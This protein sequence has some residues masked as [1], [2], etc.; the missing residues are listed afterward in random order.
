MGS[1]E[2]EEESAETALPCKAPARTY[3]SW[4]NKPELLRT[5][6]WLPALGPEQFPARKHRAGVR[7]CC[8][9]Q[10]WQR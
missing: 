4:E 7:R 1:E 9:Q 6:A 5:A 2:E 10:G 3:R 8:E